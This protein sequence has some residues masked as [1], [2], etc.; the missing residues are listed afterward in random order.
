LKKETDYVETSVANLEGRF[1][2][3]NRKSEKEN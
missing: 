3:G 2:K 1:N